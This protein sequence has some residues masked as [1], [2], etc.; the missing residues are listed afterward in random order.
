MHMNKNDYTPSEKDS[1]PELSLNIIT[2]QEH[3]ISRKQISD[4]ALK[5][6]YRLHG[7]GFDA[8]LVGGG[9]RDLLLGQNP[10]DF[11]IAT[12]ATPE[13]IRQLFKNCRLIG[14]RFRLAH[15]MFGRDIIE[16]ATFRGH[17]QETSKNISQQ[18][19]EG[20]LL[21]DNVYGTIDED[22]ERR[23][24]TI[25]AMYYNIADYAIHDYAGGN[26]DLEDR[27]VRLIG[28]PETR[29]REDPVRMLR[30]IRFAVKLDFDIE[31]DTAAPIEE[32]SSLLG[33]IP[34]ARLYEE[35]LKMLQSG[36]GLETYH[37]MREYN[38]FQQLFP[39]ISADFTEE[40]SSKTEQMLDLVLDSTDQRIEEGKR[41]NPAF[42]FAAMLWYPLQER[43]ALLMEKRKLSYYDAIM[44]ASNY[45][46]DEQVRTIAIPRRHTATIREIWQL[47]LRMPRR[48]GKR[49]FR[50][51]ELNKFRAGYDFL[52][53]RGEIEGGETGQLAKWWETFQNAGRNMRQAMVSELDSDAPEQ[54]KKRRRKP[55]RKKKNKASTS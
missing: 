4:N 15:I 24:F 6:L 32:M 21:R 37:L 12:N 42:M 5:V 26:E 22:A 8:F 19:K 31:E 14:R 3:N 40:Y 13:Q 34:S 36:Y 33:D 20:M 50:L 16:V 45:I 51:M 29:Y 30:A 18:S 2:R 1:Y 35:S 43:A 9:V 48:N 55:F 52:E 47:Q 49:A 11:D 46:L 17:H 28:D 38:L 53:M 39:I 41:I 27:L 44:E 23:D 25:N 54:G 7:A 10:K